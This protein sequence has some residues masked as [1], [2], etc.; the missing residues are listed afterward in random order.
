[1]VHHWKCTAQQLGCAACC[2]QCWL[3]H[4]HICGTSVVLLLLCQ[5]CAAVCSGEPAAGFEAIAVECG[6]VTTV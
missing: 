3:L 2:G 4:M 1:M 6:K 5:H